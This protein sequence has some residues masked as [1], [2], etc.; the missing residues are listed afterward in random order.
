MNKPPCRMIEYKNSSVIGH[1]VAF[2]I[3]FLLLYGSCF[4]ENLENEALF[5]RGL[6]QFQQG[7]YVSARLDFN[8]IITDR[9]A[10]TRIPPSY[11][12][13]SKSFYNLGDYNNAE[14][15]ALSLRKLYPESP[16]SKWALYM[17]AACRFRLGEIESAISNLA[18]LVRS[19]KDETLKSHAIGALRFSILPATD[20]DTFYSVLKNNGIDRS[21]IESAELRGTDKEPLFASQPVVDWEAQPIIK[22]GLL[23]PLTGIDSD[24]GRELLNG[25]SAALSNYPEIDGIPVELMVEDT[26]SSPIQ[27]IL[28]T[29]KLTNEGVDVI[30]GP[31]FGGPTIMA[32]MESNASGIPFLAPTATDVGIP[33]IGPFVFQL[34]QTPVAKAEALADFAAGTLGFTASAIIASE[35]TWGDTVSK[36]FKQEF[37]K[38]G[39]KVLSAEYFKPSGNVY[40]YNEQIIN[41]REHAPETIASAESLVV[42]GYGNTFS[43][44][45]FIKPDLEIFP[46]RLKPVDTIDC[47]LISAESKEAVRIASQ[48]VEYKINAFFLGDSD[49]STENISEELVLILDGSYFISSMNDQA[50]NLGSSYFKDDF[51]LKKFEL[52]SFVERKGYD[53][54]AILIHCLAQGAR[55]PDALVKKLATVRDFYGLSSRFTIDPET[56]TNMAVD[57]V[58]LKD[59]EIVKVYHNS[60]SSNN[61]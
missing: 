3:I 25:V 9:P 52:L 13:L 53:A 12:M 33:L 37:E 11:M 57:F 39:G 22:I 17:I 45:L 4:A 14:S 55:S 15:T 1:A 30:I 51:R 46:L 19:A 47:V 23:T 2:A 60:A 8:E 43:D 18:I 42:F 24:K 20:P 61:K 34:N 31:V 41:I 56:R 32:A 59:G 26:E 27:A 35:D 40:N 7:K 16:Y 54:C 48:I 38:K 6:T 36:R 50:D 21:A 49:W 5:R 28:K 58:Q 10:S 44:T 29:R